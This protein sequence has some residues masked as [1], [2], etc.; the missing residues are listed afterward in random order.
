MNIYTV[1]RATQ[2]L[3]EWLAASGGTRSVAIAHDS[4][5][6]S[7]LFAR[8]AARVLAANG[9]NGLSLSAARAHR[10]R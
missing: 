4:R 9:N 2:G 3:C 8:E 1:R 6:K 7:D 10:L 5:I